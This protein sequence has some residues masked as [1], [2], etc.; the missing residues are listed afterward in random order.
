MNELDNL[1]VQFNIVKESALV[2]LTEEEKV[3]KSDKVVSKLFSSIKK[4]ALNANFADVDASRGD[5]SKMKNYSDITNAVKYLR[6]ISAKENGNEL[7]EVVS[8]LEG[9]IAYLTKYKASF[10]SAYTKK[11]TI[12]K[13]LYQSSV[14]GLIQVTSHAVSEAIVYAETGTMI[15]AEP[16]KS[17]N[18]LKN[19]SLK[20][21]RS[22]VNLSKT[23]KM[24]KYMKEMNT[25]HEQVTIISEGIDVH[26]SSNG[27]SLKKA[28]DAVTG[29]VDKVKGAANNSKILKNLAGAATV[30]GVIAV[31]LTMIRPII[32]LF[33][34]T[35]IKL[36]QY[37]DQ[38]ADF[39]SLNASNVTDPDVKQKQEKWVERL[40]RLSAKI[41]VDQAVAS[42][43][44]EEEMNDENYNDD[45][46]EDDLGII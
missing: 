25:F 33:M 18:L 39:V 19:N 22:L 15:V 38:L 43:R 36:S 20:S 29:I 24:D 44:A 9:V 1:L 26:I 8:V 45:D 13:Y 12:I 21:L 34:V 32:Y 27:D 37:L 23:N 46:N 5:F 16:T 17:K 2:S 6:N 14:V 7:K 10:Q 35:K 28:T 42:K 4:K 41:S 11:N 3:T 31:I 30:I 40:K